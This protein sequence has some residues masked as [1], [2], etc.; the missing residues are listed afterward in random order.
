M[1]QRQ[2]EYIHSFPA[3]GHL[4]RTVPDIEDIRKDFPLALSVH[5]GGLRDPSRPQ[6]I[7]ILQNASLRH[8]FRAL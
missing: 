1:Q 8:S 4:L 6:I 5:L 3:D 7:F 2:N